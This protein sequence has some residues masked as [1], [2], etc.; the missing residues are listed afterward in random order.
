MLI[1]GVRELTVIPRV[2]VVVPPR[3]PTVPVS[4][5]IPVI[6]QATKEE[7][8]GARMRV[9]GLRIVDRAIRQLARLRDARVVVA[10]DGSIPL[11]RR[12]PPNIER[13]VIE[14]DVA[15]GLA[16]LRA[17]LGPETI[18]VGADTVWLAP[19]RFEKGLKV[20]D[21]ASCRA[22]SEAVYDDLQSVARG[23]FDRLINLKI[24]SWL[25]RM[26]FAN[27]PITPAL[28]TLMGGFVGVYGALMVAAGGSPNVVI[29][30]AALQGYVILDACAAALARLR[31][32]RSGLGAWLDTMIGDFVSVVLIL[33][34]G[35]AL[36]THGGTFL[37]MKMA[38]V[39][40]AL[41]L[42]YAV[43]SY[44]ELVRQKEGDVT[45]LR[46][47][48]AHGQTLRSR[49][50]LGQPIDPGGDDD[51]PP[52]LRD[53]RGARAGVLR[54]ALDRAAADADRR[55]L[56]RGRG[57]HRSCSRPPGESAR[58]R[59]PDHRRRRP[60]RQRQVPVRRRPGGR[61]RGQWSAG[62]LLHIDDFRR[63]VAFPGEDADAEASFYYERYF[64]LAKLDRELASI[65]RGDRRAG[66]HR[67]GVHPAR[68]DGGFG[69][70]AGGAAREPG[71][72]A[73]ADRR[74]GSRQ[75]PFRRGYPP[76]H[77]ATVFP[78]H[79]RYRAELDPDAR[80]DAI[81]DN[82][83]WLRPRVVRREPGRFP[84]P[85]ERLFDGLTR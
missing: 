35:R 30:F 44:R 67:R 29:G 47:W 40:A 58:S 7:A 54:S 38:G 73:P 43:V 60:G 9:G 12:L 46:W 50:G 14:G 3:P 62:D 57:A 75:G 51:G 15:A 37:D 49:Q 71:R 26:L 80:A 64:D 39:G 36:W 10:T 72:G 23:L 66:D 82:E 11:P 28:L 52:R 1:D 22:A 56:A 4:S 2:A 19:A 76:P 25:T 61:V 45:R 79:A 81:V 63:D 41:T 31:L 32:N 69:G 8:I 34:V 53:R 55:G 16:A 68:T 85:V 20:V 27:V 78:A 84:P 77:R 21:A 6:L 65:Q 13:R 24:A 17:E 33:A 59:D 70:G 42:I 74:T 48:F 83:D 5:V 18:S